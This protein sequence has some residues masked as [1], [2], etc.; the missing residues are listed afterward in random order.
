RV[1]P[2]SI[3]APT[4]I[5]TGINGALG[6]IGV[7]PSLIAADRFGILANLR[8]AWDAM[9]SQWNQWVL[10]YNVERQRQF[11]SRLGLD[12]FDWRQVAAWLLGI[13]LAV[14]GAVALALVAR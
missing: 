10:G 12:A 8:F 7:I 5:E 3:V 11:L 4:R 1:D 2:T 6:P 14:G 13:T 9:N